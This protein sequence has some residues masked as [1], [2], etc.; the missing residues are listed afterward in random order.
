MQDGEGEERENCR[1]A[2]RIKRQASTEKTCNTSSVIKPSIQR[3]N[4]LKMNERMNGTS[5]SISGRAG[6]HA[7]NCEVDK[8]GHLKT[9]RRVCTERRINTGPV[10]VDA[11]KSELS[12]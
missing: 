12:M 11:V 3:T 10:R 4:T 8:S 6:S 7:A 9:Q 1:R 2:D 5:R